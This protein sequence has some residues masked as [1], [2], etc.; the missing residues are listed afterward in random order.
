MRMNILSALLYVVFP[1]AIYSVEEVH[2]VSATRERRRQKQNNYY[3][4]TNHQAMNARELTSACTQ[5]RLATE[6]T[7]EYQHVCRRIC[8]MRVRYVDINIYY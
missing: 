2:R 8:V 4:N 1:L 6:G 7:T 5:A 3:C